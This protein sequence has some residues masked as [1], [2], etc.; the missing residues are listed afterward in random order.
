MDDH[1]AV[2]ILVVVKMTMPFRLIVISILRTMV[3][4]LMILLILNLKHI[5]VAFKEEFEGAVGPKV[6]V[7]HL[8]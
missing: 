7:E 1:D 2:L 5:F 4:M 8:T 3:G 6:V